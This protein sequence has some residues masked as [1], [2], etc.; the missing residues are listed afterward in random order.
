VNLVYAPPVWDKVKLFHR[1]E[2]SGTRYLCFDY[3]DPEYDKKWGSTRDNILSSVGNAI[4]AAKARRYGHVYPLTVLTRCFDDIKERL[5]Y[6]LNLS[7]TEQAILLLTAP[8]EAFH[9]EQTER[10]ELAQKRGVIEFDDIQYFFKEGD[11]VIVDFQGTTV[12]GVYESMSFVTSMFGAYYEVKLKVIH[13]LSLILQFA[14]LITIIGSFDGFHKIDEL[15]IRHISKAEKESLHKR[16]L[17]Y[18]EYTTGPSYLHYTGTLVRSNWWTSKSFRATGRIMI[19]AHSYSQIDSNSWRD[20]TYASS[21]DLQNQ[22]RRSIA[23]QKLVL[24]DDDLWRTYPFLYGFSFAAKT[25][26]RMDVSK[27]EPIQWRTQAWDQLV[28]EPEHKDLV[29]ALVEYSGDSFEDLVAGKGGGTIFLLEGPPGQGKTLSAET[30]AEVLKRPLYSISVG[31]L[32][33]DPDVL[34][35]RLREILDVAMI[36]NAVLLLD[37]ADIFL[38]QRTS[39]DIVRNAMVGVFLRLL[40]YHSG[41][42]FLTS[43]RMDSI[44]KAFLSRISVHLH[45]D[46]ASEEKRAQIWRNLLQAAKIPISASRDEHRLAGL[47]NINGRQIKNI[48]RLAQTLAKSKNQKANY[49]W[50]VKVMKLC[51]GLKEKY[52]NEH[53]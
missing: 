22:E 20:E 30:V 14:S 7:S 26:G 45:F 52:K 24:S 36:W 33:T 3:E 29:K 1:L 21:L 16:G 44:D 17:K 43:N 19:D 8:I 53:S 6:D 31:E 12:G 34:E 46:E 28:L 27:M 49:D 15:P 35:K 50:L 47:M 18:R 5:S 51:Y 38:E 48:I 11:E 4:G 42:L 39:D 41:I 13:N 37:E 9:L 10:M 32:G 2:R 23:S 40:E 25:W